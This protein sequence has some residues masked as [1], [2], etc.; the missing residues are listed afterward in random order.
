MVNLIKRAVV[1]EFGVK[2]LVLDTFFLSS[3]CGLILVRIGRGSSMA[4]D[5]LQWIFLTFFFKNLIIL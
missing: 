1:G 4:D 2:E 5:G 3:I